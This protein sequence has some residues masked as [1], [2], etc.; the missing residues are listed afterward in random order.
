MGNFGSRSGAPPP[1]PRLFTAIYTG[2]RRR[3]T[4]GTLVGLRAPLHRH[5]HRWRCQR[6]L[7]GTGPWR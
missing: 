2:C 3:I 4:I 1:P 5:C 7:S 6:R